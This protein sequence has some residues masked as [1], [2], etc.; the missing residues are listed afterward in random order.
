MAVNIIQINS[1]TLTPQTYNVQ[2]AD[3]ISSFE[4]NTSF[5]TSSYIEYFV[6]DLD[7]FL[8][9]SQYNYSKYK[10]INDGQSPGSNNSITQVEID[11]END[12]NTFLIE[13]FF[14]LGEYITVYNFLNKHVGSYL[15]YLYISE[16]SADRTEIRLDSNLLDNASIIEQ[17]KN[18]IFKREDSDYF[19]DFYL[20][21]G[22]NNLLI[23]NNFALDDKD[24][25][26]PTVLVKLY[27]PLP[28]DFDLNSTAWIVSQVETPLAYQISITEDP[29]D[30]NDN[31]SIKGPNFN[32]DLKDQVNNSTVPLSYNDITSTPLLSS[33]NQL[34]SLL[35]EKEIDINIDYTDFNDFIHF[36]SAQTRLENFYYK[37]SL[38]E[39]YSSSIASINTNIA[40]PTSASL[41]I[42]ESK[43]IL[44]A[45][46]SDIITNF[47]GYDY[48]LY[49]TSGSWAWPK[50]NIEPP[51][52]LYP[53]NSPQVETWYNNIILSASNYDNLN[54]DNLYYAIP[55]YLRDD[56]NNQPYELFL[57]MVG[58]H[59][60][61]IWIYYKDV[62][63]KYDADNRLE[64]G[65][66]KDIVADAIRDFGVKLYQNN[67]SNQDLYT[68]FLGLTPDGAL[69]PFPN[70]T[71]SLPTPT[72]FEY[73][74][75][76]ISASND[77]IPLDDV[78][79]SLYKRIY[80]NLPYLLK[81][82][83]TLPGLRALITS[84]G[85][86]DTILRI[87]EYGGKDKVN[88]N[89]WDYWQNEFN[90]SF[91]T[92]GNN[93]ISSSFSPINPNWSV[94]ATSPESLMFRFKTN[95][96]PTTNI[97]YSQSLWS[98]QSDTAHIVLR[99][100]GPGY[101]SGSYS[102]SIIDPYYQYAYLDFYPSYVNYPN[103]SASIYL[104]F[105]DNGWWS[106]MVNVDTSASPNYNFSLY[107]A[108]K[109]YEGGDNGTLLG[110][111]A[112][113]SLITDGAD[114]D[115]N[116]D[117][118]FASSSVINGN[119][120]TQFSGSLQEIRYYTNPLSESV[121]RDYVMNPCSIEGNSLNSGPNELAFRASLGS[122]L[123]T[124]SI[125]IHPKITG[126]WAITNSFTSNSNFYFDQTPT[127]FPNT[128][129]FFY[130]QPVAGIKNTVSDK[131]R[132]EN[133]TLPS[134]S[135][136][137]PL[138]ALSQTTAA[139]A[140]YTPNIN[141]LEVSFSP[142]NEINE[143]IMDQ[144]GFFNMGDYI[145]DPAFRFSPLQSYPELNSIRDYYFEKYT[146]NYDLVDF[147]RL[148]KFFD[149][150]LFK[151]IKD[152]VPARTSLAS[153]VVIKQHLLERNRY[154]QPQIN[155][156]DLDISGTIKSTQVWNP[157][158]QS[159]YISHSLIEE[160]SGG[161]LGSFEVF[162]GIDT[163]PYGVDGNGPDNRFGITQ[164]WSESFATPL[165][166]AIIIHDAQDEFYDGEFSGSLIVVTTQSLNQPYPATPQAF[167]YRQVHYYGA[168]YDEQATYNNLFLN[169][170]T[171]PQPGEILFF[172]V[173]QNTPPA[174]FSPFRDTKYIKIAKIDCDGNNHSIPL[175]STTQIYVYNS[176]SNSYTP[177]TITDIN[178]YPSYYIY[179]ANLPE[180]YFPPVFPNQVFDYY[181][182]AS[183]TAAA[184]PFLP[185]AGFPLTNFDAGELGDILGYFDTGSG[186]YTLENTPNT[187]LQI[188]ASIPISA[189]APSVGTVKMG[190]V[191]ERNGV[192]TLLHDTSFNAASAPLTLTLTASFYPLNGDQIYIQ[193]GAGPSTLS[194]TTAS[195]LITQS[196][197]VSASSCDPVIFEP[198]ITIP[199]F[200]NSDENAL[201]NNA[202]DIR[203]SNLFQDV[204]YSSGIITPTNFYAILSGSALPAPVQEYNYT[205]ARSIYPRYLGSKSTSQ[206]LNKWN[207]GDT[208]TY[209]KLPTVENSKT[210]VAY[211][212]T[213]GGY[214][215][216]KMNTS[217]VFVK[218]FISED[219][220][221]V[222]PDTSPNALSINKQ[223]FNTG[224][225]VIIESLGEGV[226]PY[227]Q[228]KN[229]FRG[230]AS[231]APILTNQIRHYDNPP[232]TFTGSIRFTDN[233]PTSTTT[234][235]DFT[236]TFKPTAVF[237]P[238]TAGTW[239][240]IDMG[241]IIVTGSNLTPAAVA[242]ADQ[243][244]ITNDVINENIDLVFTAKVAIKYFPDVNDL[245][246][247]T[248]AFARLYS[249]GGYISQTFYAGNGG[250]IERN[251]TGVIQFTVTVPKTQFAA[252]D[253]FQVQVM[254]GSTE[255]FISNTNSFFKVSQNPLPTPPVDAY[256]WRS[257]SVAGYEN[258][259]FTTSS[260]VLQ[261]YN[262]PLTHQVDISGS[263]FFPITLPFTIEPGDE[264]RFE[265]DE[266]KT[267]MVERANIIEP[268]GFPILVAFLD[269]P[270]SGSGI[271]INQ[272]LL[273]R[274][275]D[276][277]SGIVL[278]GLKPPGFDGPY[279]VKPE[280]IS[281]KMKENIGKYIEDFTQKGLL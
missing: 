188:T 16:I 166:T 252:G 76:L 152:F 232:M 235:N 268:F 145:G 93:F 23:A 69:F 109:I 273:R 173:S 127:F 159:S 33:N 180:F 18:F 26:N 35:E 119:I 6:Y 171:I 253:A 203:T 104:P 100:T 196:R 97:P 215:P 154:P 98:K 158:S 212:D 206:Q 108:N 43:T 111:I 31:I 45:K 207:P 3:L 114:W 129:Y 153:G 233:N 258:M 110:F 117:S 22:D 168:G 165:G 178:E 277:A 208:G 156:E 66:S 72:G 62:S 164:S 80:H 169:Q 34:K 230:G 240:D 139:S 122:E 231:I 220:D 177:Y 132:L 223:T 202:V 90:Y 123:Y 214:A 218:Y 79:K 24:F 4:I 272:Y 210:Y 249:S 181:T 112:S 42:S 204:D 106:I 251:K 64:Y 103:L 280:Y 105:F 36:S 248:T 174:V 275:V 86:P 161:T 53:T 61:N 135:V 13:D 1:E 227:T 99:Y 37:V 78:N 217:G 14:P 257:S 85:V 199:N 138:R 216:E 60:D 270:I 12:I 128:E 167:N 242:V 236:A 55:E 70:I 30:I 68:A 17:S 201:I 256:F 81:S 52:V 190:I 279:L 146:K 260:Q 58:Q 193:R 89:D 44:E 200:Y 245:N 160:F 263:G 74:D 276:N 67:F 96:L 209:G 211:S 125:S 250:F 116:G 183:R 187:P 107:A 192:K 176:L 271:N 133:D 101:T 39:Q 234:V 38:I 102:G 261:Y 229:I 144:L 91:Y 224:E 198:Y 41:T 65:I 50:S 213:I 244:I 186:V 149:N 29:I 8:L 197:A 2:E 265:G 121:F 136:L 179:E 82:K 94:T 228:T 95:G 88:S 142:Q 120:Y 189:S 151:M 134:G 266:T 11:P 222:A 247:S 27:D 237:Q 59:F 184:V 172:N 140:S 25:L 15:E 267:F 115:N 63:E 9:S 239:I 157:A 77:Y 118:Y 47:D 219:G 87:N 185:V 141:Y 113:S 54:K 84:Y 49:Y 254:V 131:I 148:I 175:G 262:N 243:Y 92:E 20:N 170:A 10:V 264:F 246:T 269:G 259:I 75:T 191:S 163:S 7:Q 278:D 5:N 40:G 238:P 225:N 182:S 28:E 19:F 194:I 46:I 155:W 73:V 274:Y 226:S 71:G 162:N 137:S 130:D 57:G 83:G 124:G 56:P 32:L 255:T 48:Y 150:S 195:I 205:I 147:I 281:S 21:F 126:S 241:S 143:D 221:L 51:Y